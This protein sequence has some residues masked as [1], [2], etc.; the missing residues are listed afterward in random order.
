MGWLAGGGG[1]EVVGRGWWGEEAQ[2][3]VNAA[4]W[5]EGDSWG[6]RHAQH[7]I[8]QGERKEGGKSQSLY[9]WVVSLSIQL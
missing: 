3:E 9:M 7:F 6:A 4:F 8:T 5:C 1:G 2:R